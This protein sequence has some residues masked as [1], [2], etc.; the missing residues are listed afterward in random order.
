MIGVDT[1]FFFVPLVYQIG[2]DHP[3]VHLVFGRDGTWAV[4]VLLVQGC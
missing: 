1:S 4:L 2:F 3:E